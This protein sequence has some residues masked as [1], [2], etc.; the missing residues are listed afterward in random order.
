MA[1][2]A[3]VV[4]AVSVL[5]TM[6]LLPAVVT[7]FGARR[8]SKRWPTRSRHRLSVAQRWTSFVMRRP[9]VNLAASTCFLLIL[10]I[11]VISLHVSSGALAQ[12]DQNDPTRIGFNEATKTVG[13]G[14]LGPVQLLASRAADLPAG[15]F[16]QWADQTSHAIEGLSGVHKVEAVEYAQDGRNALI[17]VIPN[18]DPESSGPKQLVARL[19]RLSPPHGVTVTIGGT[20]ATQLDEEH[21]VAASMWK[22]VVTVL[23]LAFLVLVLLL[24]APVLALKAVLT[25]L[26]SVGAAYGVLVAVFQWGWLHHALNYS[27]LGH[28]ETFTPPLILAIAFGLS[29]DYEVFLLSRIREH[30]SASGDTRTAVEKGVAS[31]ARTISSA[32]FIL[33]CVFAVFI[34]TGMPAI[35]E[36]GLGAA[37]A[38]GLDAT[39][40]R[41]M[42]VP[43]LMSLLGDVSWWVP[44]WMAPARTQQLAASTASEALLLSIHQSEN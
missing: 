35:K 11:P 20:S 33:V 37:V 27:A 39:V 32:A 40:V 4:V 26:L 18:G 28:L 41:L 7:V 15:K 38:I 29:T 13:A 14:T 43:A 5:A 31:S 36:I 9:V 16:R 23:A 34:G 17:S 12:L 30:W 44:R 3:I 42:L 19:R 10:C 8:I 25:T 21:A 22:V 24:R 1:L 6:I 2:G